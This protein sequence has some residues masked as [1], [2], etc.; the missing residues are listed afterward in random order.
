MVPLNILSDYF[1]D[2]RFRVS[3]VIYFIASA[4]ILSLI[5]W[6]VA[7]GEYR[8]AKIDAPMKALRK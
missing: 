5:E 2:A 4:P 7:E 8:A 3:T 1:F 6:W